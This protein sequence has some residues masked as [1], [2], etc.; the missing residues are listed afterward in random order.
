MCEQLSPS[1]VNDVLLS[2]SGDHSPRQTEL[3][4]L[5]KTGKNGSEI[6]LAVPTASSLITEQ[7]S[8]IVRRSKLQQGINLFKPMIHFFD[9]VL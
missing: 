1:S 4:K 2:N 9:L 7:P 8:Q 3:E 6:R 5:F